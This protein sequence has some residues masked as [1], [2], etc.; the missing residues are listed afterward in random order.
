MNE[1]PALRHETLGYPRSNREGA[2][3]IMTP[4]AKKPE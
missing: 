4:E 2:L 1:T 3:P